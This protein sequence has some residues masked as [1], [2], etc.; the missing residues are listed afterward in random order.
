VSAAPE[1]AGLADLDP[2]LTSPKRLA[3]MA[4]LS[5][6][7]STDFAYLR[8]HLEVSDSDLSKQMTALQS[9]GYVEVTKAGRG[10]GGSTSYRATSA[11]RAAY[12]RHR[13]VLRAIVA[14]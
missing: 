3:A 1:P 2:T 6:S 12:Q 9:A 7:S 8:A 5:R 11:G 10:R 4:V 13:A 14:D